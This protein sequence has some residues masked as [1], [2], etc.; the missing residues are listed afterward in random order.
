M[1][2]YQATLALF[3]MDGNILET[4]MTVHIAEVTGE[5][6]T[7]A[8]HDALFQIA[9]KLGYQLTRPVKLPEERKEK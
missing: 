1:E 2:K 5:D 4:T 7:D 9:E 6:R 8:L 3:P